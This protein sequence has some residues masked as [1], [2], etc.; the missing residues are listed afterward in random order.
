MPWD[1]STF[2]KHNKKLS[3]AEASKAAKQANAILKSSGDEGI[4][5][6]TANKEANRRRGRL[7]THEKSK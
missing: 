4:A 1:A 6:A 7:Y 3:E 5:I 2:H